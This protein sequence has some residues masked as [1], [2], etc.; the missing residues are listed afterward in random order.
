MN[1]IIRVTPTENYFS[2][3]WE[4][5]TRCNY[6]CMYC[7]PK[8]HDDHSVPHTLEK[9]QQAW[10]KI[11]HATKYHQLPYKIAFTG[12]ELTTSKYFLPFVIWLRQ[13]YD[14]YLFRLL[15]TT[16]GSANFQYYRRL[17]ESMDNITFSVHSEHM[18][19]KKFF[20][21]VI[22]LKQYIGSDKFIHV[23]IMKEFWNLDRIPIYSRLLDQ[24]NISY[25]INEIDYSYQTR[26]IPIMTGKSNLEV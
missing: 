14:D 2:L 17:F 4:V 26:H 15:L 12:G 9:L 25:T 11:W 22:K 5:G 1:K 20:N 19:E 24:H 3:N 16:N 10:L 21:L 8:W 13:N 23:A 6:D 18:D 7:S